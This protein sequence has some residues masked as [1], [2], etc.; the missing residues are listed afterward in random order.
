M[1]KNYFKYLGF[2]IG[3]HPSNVIKK[4]TRE[5]LHRIHDGFQGIEKS[6]SGTLKAVSLS[7]I[8]VSS[9]DLMEREIT[10]LGLRRWCSS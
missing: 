8:L 2:K 1:T 4:W 10:D 9:K 7:V 3:I 6:A 5:E